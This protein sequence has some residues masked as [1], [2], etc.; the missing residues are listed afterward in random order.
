M[1][2]PAPGGESTDLGGVAITGVG[3]V[4]SLGTS[5]QACAADR[6]GITRARELPFVAGMDGIEPARVLGHPVP[7]VEG[8]EG[9]GRLVCLARLALEDLSEGWQGG[10][11]S[12]RLP[13]IM[14]VPPIEERAELLTDVE[15]MSPSPDD[16]SDLGKLLFDR[17]R[18]AVPWGRRAAPVLVVEGEQ[19]AAFE[20][21][22]EAARQVTAGSADACVVCC[23]DS[24]LDRSM[25]E[26]LLVTRRLKTVSNPT[27]LMPGEC[28][29]AFVVERF[30]PRREQNRRPL[31][32]L[33]RLGQAEATGGEEEPAG[34][35]AALSRALVH[36]LRPGARPPPLA[37]VDLN[38]EPERA[39]I[40]GNA[41][42]R[43]QVQHPV[44]GDLRTSTPAAN[45]GEVG[46][47]TGGLFI[48]LALAAF[49]RGYAGGDEMLLVCSSADGEARTLVVA[50][51]P[52]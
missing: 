25:L 28:A 18:D 26:T 19:P 48:C 51:P 35:I 27:G 50:A 42:V 10:A 24:L 32:R 29:A 36:A 21:L 39:N 7:F 3:L 8:Y 45:F 33:V 4:S 22:S 15:A 52:P 14:V 9:V 46:A 1:T 12:G 30:H 5:V 6:A 44:L 23:V 40:W 31:G 20:A 11:T 49:A 34:S 38:G 47:A 37:L 17:A 2:R 13:V 43:A 16:L 41:L